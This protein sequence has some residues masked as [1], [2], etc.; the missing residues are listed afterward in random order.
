M[1]KIFSA[2]GDAQESANRTTINVFDVRLMVKFSV[3]LIR[4]RIA[5][6]SAFQN[7]YIGAQK[8]AN[9]IA[10]K[11]AYQVVLELYLFMQLSMHK[12][13]QYDSIKGEI[14]VALYAALEDAS[15]ISF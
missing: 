12:A 9:K 11:G 6:E 15:K 14:E 2:P 7:L 13:L 5:L 8:G 10:L 3:H 4:H 1:S